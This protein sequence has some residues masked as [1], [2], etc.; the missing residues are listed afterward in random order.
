MGAELDGGGGGVSDGACR[1][2]R[3][4]DEAEGCGCVQGDNGGG[5]LV[6]CATADEAC[7]STRVDQHMECF[8]CTGGEGDVGLDDEVI[9]V[10]DGMGVGSR[11]VENQ[12]GRDGVRESWRGAVAKWW[13]GVMGW[14]CTDAITVQA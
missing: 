2:R 13:C 4:I 10:N 9:C 3:V 6:C 5:E 8:G 14:A 11:E 12:L 1:S 7:C